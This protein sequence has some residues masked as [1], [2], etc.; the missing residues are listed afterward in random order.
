MKQQHLHIMLFVLLLS[1]SIIASLSSANERNRRK[2][3]EG[4]DDK[5]TPGKVVKKYIT[6]PVTAIGAS[7]AGTVAGAKKV[8]SVVRRSPKANA[9]T[10]LT[11]GES[12]DVVL[13]KTYALLAFASY[14]KSTQPPPGYTVLDEINNDNTK[15]FAMIL[16]NAAHDE[17]V[18]SFRGTRPQYW[19]NINQD[20][21]F[22]RTKSEA[23]RGCKVHK[24]FREALLNIK[25]DVNASVNKHLHGITKI[26][27]TGH[28]LGAAMAT[29]YAVHLRNSGIS[30]GIPV[31]LFTYGSPRVG[32]KEFSRECNRLIPDHVRVVFRRDPITHIPFGPGDIYKHTG[33]LVYFDDINTMTIFGEMDNIGFKVANMSNG[34]GEHGKYKQIVS[35]VPAL[36]NQI[37][38]EIDDSEDGYGM[39]RKKRNVRRSKK[40][41]K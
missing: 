21:S 23:C 18:I 29:L 27:V 14:K 30:F 9:P 41:N 3:K 36:D 22:L 35:G 31:H 17:L 33:T 2:K 12:I 10:H 15:N 19:E 38:P 32:N 8:E 24:G 11:T 28:S 20:L 7:V 25:Q 1:V 6:T 34:P 26:S 16:I 37:N 4:D 39:K 13:I 40:L 5:I